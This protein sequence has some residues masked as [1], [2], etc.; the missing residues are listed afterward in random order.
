MAIPALAL[1]LAQFIPSLIGR[2]AGPKGEAVAETVVKVAE[3]ITG[4][5]GD[6]V[7]EALKANPEMLLQ[8]QA[9]M[10]E[11][12]A[13]WAEAELNAQKEVIIAEAEGESWL[14]RNWRP[15]TM[16]VF[17]GLVTAKWMGWTAP[18]V[19]TEIELSVLEIIKYGLSGYV[20]GRS[21]EKVA[22]Y[23]SAMFGKK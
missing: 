15:G 18:G 10:M 13:H 5:S 19:T 12:Q 4:T 22:P 23:V 6:K 1:A 2:I 14:Q 16:V 17:V 3:S 9:K 8:Y 21:V 11:H 7:V 20:V